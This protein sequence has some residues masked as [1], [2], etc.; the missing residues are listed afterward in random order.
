MVYGTLPQGPLAILS[1]S[2][3]GEEDDPVSVS[4][5]TEEMIGELKENLETAKSYAAEHSKIAQT[6]YANYYNLR[7]RDKK[8][9]MHE[10]VLVLLPDSTSSKVFARWRG[11]GKI[12]EMVSPY[13]L[14]LLKLMA[15]ANSCMQIKYANFTR[16][17]AK[18]S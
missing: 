17:S 15:S 8:F 4:K 3:T 2:F 7:S 16:A 10:P 1:R 6:Q 11:P 9:E 18:F 12:V 5:S 13:I 14:T